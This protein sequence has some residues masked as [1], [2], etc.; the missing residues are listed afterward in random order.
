M[1][2]KQFVSIENRLRRIAAKLEQPIELQEAAASPA[3]L[4]QNAVAVCGMLR[5]GKSSFIN[6]VL[7]TNLLPVDLPPNLALLNSYHISVTNG[8]LPFIKAHF[9]SGVIESV[10]T[11]AID[12]DQLETWGSELDFIEIQ[13]PLPNFPEGLQLIETPSIGM[14]DFGVRTQSILDRVSSVILVVDA[15]LNLSRQE[16]EFLQSLPTNIE[17]LIVAANKIDIVNSEMRSACENRIFEQIDALELDLEVDVFKISVEAAF[18]E[19]ESY[20]WPQLTTKLANLAM[21]STKMS[22]GETKTA[23]TQ[24]AQLLKVAENLQTGLQTKRFSRGTISTDDTSAKKIAELQ[25]TKRLIE[26]VIDD[27]KRD[28]LQTVRNSLE[29]EMFQLESDIRARRK[30]PQSLEESLERWLNRE[31]R[32]VQE[33]LERHFQSILDDTNYAVEGAYTLNVELDEISVTAFREQNVPSPTRPFS[34][35][36][37]YLITF[38]AGGTTTMVV[39][40]ITKHLPNSLMG[41]GMVAGLAWLFSD[42]LSTPSRH[43]TLLPDLTSAVMPQFQRNV[44]HNTDRLSAL[45]EK[46]FTEAIENAKTSSPRLSNQ[47]Y[48]AMHDE[49][50]SITDELKGMIN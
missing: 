24:A 28:I 44:R 6:A 39:L 49:L 41:G 42:N 18:T 37:R 23:S 1:S 35:E 46:A 13:S 5:C 22:N 50:S 25:R 27:Q 16:I 21:V 11:T 14:V 48:N 12:K 45:V 17:Y 34:K 26:E 9:S 47:N 36:L 15:N 7:T 10:E 43:E 33:R 8:R 20:D 38:G 40:A 19:P 29:A 32:R 30:D 3:N 31:C 2:S 4:G